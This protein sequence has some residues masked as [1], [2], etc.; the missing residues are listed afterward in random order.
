M[1]SRTEKVNKCV[2]VVEVFAVLSVTFPTL[3]LV[4]FAKY[5]LHI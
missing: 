2:C 1:D 5:L 4:V 3:I